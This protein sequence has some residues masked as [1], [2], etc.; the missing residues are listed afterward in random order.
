L[1]FTPN[2]AGSFSGTI[3]VLSNATGGGGA[4]AVSGKGVPPTFLHRGSGTP[5]FNG[6]ATTVTHNFQSAPATWLNIEFTDNLGD[7]NSWTPHSASVYSQGGEFPV[8][9]TK[10]GDHRA[11]WQRGMFFRLSYPTKP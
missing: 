2:A 9:F 10:P 3:S 5:Q 11:N 8:T 6:S 4:V 7:T 1:V